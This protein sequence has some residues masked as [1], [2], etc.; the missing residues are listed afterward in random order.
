RKLLARRLGYSTAHVA[1]VGAVRLHERPLNL[2][3]IGVVV[4]AGQPLASVEHAQ[5]SLAGAFLLAGALVLVIALVAS[6]VAGVRVSA[7]LR[8][9]AQAAARVDAG[10]LT[11]RMEVSRDGRGELAILAE[12]FNHMLD[13]LAH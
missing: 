8:R 10:E 3:G 13:R 9:M 5:H 6:Y 11:P 2:A 1:D 7:P 4:A 12:A